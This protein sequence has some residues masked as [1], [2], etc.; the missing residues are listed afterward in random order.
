MMIV[1]TCLFVCYMLTVPVVSSSHACNVQSFAFFSAGC[2]L[3]FISNV[4][5]F[6]QASVLGSDSLSVSE[7]T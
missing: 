6:I 2:S 4:H 5:C 7:L 1:A 3:H